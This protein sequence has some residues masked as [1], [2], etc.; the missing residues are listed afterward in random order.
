MKCEHRIKHYNYVFKKGY[1]VLIVSIGDFEQKGNTLIELITAFVQYNNNDLR[2][3]YKYG[4]INKLLNSG[5]N[6]EGCFEIGFEHL[7]NNIAVDIYNSDNELQQK[8]L[9]LAEKNFP[10]SIFHRLK[11]SPSFDKL[12]EKILEKSICED[13]KKDFEKHEMIEFVLNED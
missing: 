10:N 4:A 6:I 3:Q 2:F 8:A 9:P 11:T 13:L 7:I 12:K 1:P 5:V